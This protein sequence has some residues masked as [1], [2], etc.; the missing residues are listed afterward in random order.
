MNQQMWLFYNKYSESHNKIQ[1][2]LES[3]NNKTGYSIYEI[4]KSLNQINFSGINYSLLPHNYLIGSFYELCCET[5][6]I[7]T[8]TLLQKNMGDI[9]LTK[10]NN[11]SDE[12]F[13]S[14]NLFIKKILNMENVLFNNQQT[15]RFGV[16]KQ[17][18]KNNFNRKSQIFLQQSFSKVR[19]VY[20]KLLENFLNSYYSDSFENSL[21]EFQKNLIYILKGERV[22]LEYLRSLVDLYESMN[23]TLTMQRAQSPMQKLGPLNVKISQSVIFGPEVSQQTIDTFNLREKA[24]NSKL[25]FYKTQVT[26]VFLVF[27]EN[28]QCYTNVKEL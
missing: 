9:N 19:E 15:K 3:G 24:S 25:T 23:N 12:T 2:I 17:R 21:K 4:I 22:T 11:N 16:T 8:L 26:G 13:E 10:N 14:L 20:F 7:L 6:E 28:S 27:N 1:Q 5:E 18:K